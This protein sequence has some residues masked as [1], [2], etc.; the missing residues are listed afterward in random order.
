M[1]MAA[2]RIK[3]LAEI[4]IEGFLIRHI[5]NKTELLREVSQSKRQS[6][7]AAINLE[8]LTDIF[9]SSAVT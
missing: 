7:A 9:R 5:Y 8:I 6:A 2:T 3:V 1:L 4:F